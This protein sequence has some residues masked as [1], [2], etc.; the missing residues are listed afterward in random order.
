MRF[1]I[2][3]ANLLEVLEAANGAGI[4]HQF[5][6]VRESH[7]AKTLQWERDGGVSGFE[8]TL[9]ADGTWTATLEHEL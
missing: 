2:T 9:V 6:E 7:G 1:T 5:V 8:I 4:P 3:P